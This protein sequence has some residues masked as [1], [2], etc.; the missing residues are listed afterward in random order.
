MTTALKYKTA[1]I[2]TKFFILELVSTTIREES[3]NGYSAIRTSKIDIRLF[4]S[5]I[6]IVK[7]IL[8][9]I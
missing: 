9:A 3:V 8:G 6:R 1:K 7:D 4:G 5:Q 2:R